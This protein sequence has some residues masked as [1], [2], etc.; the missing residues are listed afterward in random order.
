MLQ[1]ANLAGK[2]INIAKT[3]GA[4]AISYV[5]TSKFN[6]PHGQAV[7]LTLPAWYDFNHNCN[8]NNINESGEG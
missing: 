3:S 1:A 6:I 2:A 5:L 7:A 4:H 8:E